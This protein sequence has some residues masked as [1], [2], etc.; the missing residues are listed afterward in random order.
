M[1]KTLNE[2][3]IALLTSSVILVILFS[4]PWLREKCD[5]G[6]GVYVKVIES[7]LTLDLLPFV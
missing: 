5:E 7:F 4:T 1:Q 6:L 3:R 2:V